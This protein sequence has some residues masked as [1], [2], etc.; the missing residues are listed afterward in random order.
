MKKILAGALLFGALMFTTGAVLACDKDCDCGCQQGKECNCKKESLKDC[1]CG[2]HKGQTCDRKKCKS[3]DCDCAKNIEKEA[4][5]DE[6]CTCGCH[7]GEKC[8]CDENCKC[9]K[10]GICEC[11]KAKCDCG[12]DS[13]KATK[14]KRFSFFKKENKIE[15]NCEK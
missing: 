6:D 14:K 2:C 3:E 13:E 8:N 15:C 11:D 10:E 12:C 7:K 9:C 4:K 5:C 1:D